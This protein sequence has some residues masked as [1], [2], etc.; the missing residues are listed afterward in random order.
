[1]IRKENFIRLMKAIE[2]QNDFISSL[3]ENY[4]IDLTN[5]PIG[6]LETI[7]ENVL[8]SE[9]GLSPRFNDISYWMWELEFGKKWKPGMV[10][11]GDE[12]IKLQTAEDLYDY[13][14]R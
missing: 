6:D 5:S 4:K 9:F 12:D 8:I 3:Y 7:V 11:D 13:I 10:M 1:M 2:N 14:S